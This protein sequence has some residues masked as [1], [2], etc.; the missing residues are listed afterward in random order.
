MVMDK[1]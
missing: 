1:R